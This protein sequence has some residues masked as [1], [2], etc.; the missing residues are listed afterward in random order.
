MAKIASLPKTRR[1]AALE[2]YA[3]AIYLLQQDHERVTTSLLAEH[4]GLTPASI[5]GMLQKMAR[6][7]LVT[8][9]P[10][11]GVVLTESGT[12]IAL[13]TLRHHRLLEAFLVEALDFTWDEVHAEAEVLEHAISETLEARIAARL[14]H[15]T[16]DPHG[17]PIPLPD[18]TLP[19]HDCDTLAELPTGDAATV[20]RVLDQ[21]ADRLRYLQDLGLSPGQPVMVHARAPFDGPLRVGAGAAT[22][23]LDSRMARSILVR[24]TA[25]DVERAEP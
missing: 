13:E 14:G 9:T 22:H 24:K 7:N 25:P 20:V 19:P 11:H 18:L 16:V 3:K 15:P 4:L 6:L 21:H 8:Y 2:D 1:S 5:T 12:R 23:V 17:D 10:Y